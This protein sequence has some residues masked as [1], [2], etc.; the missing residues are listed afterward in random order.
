MQHHSL[1]GIILTSSACE[2]SLSDNVS[3]CPMA[4]A[5][6]TLLS[7]SF[8]AGISGNFCTFWQLS[9]CSA[10]LTCPKPIRVFEEWLL[11]PL[12]F[13]AIP[14]QGVYLGTLLSGASLACHVGLVGEC[15]GWWHISWCG[16]IDE[17]GL[18]QV[19]IPSKF[20]GVLAAERVRVK[21]RGQQ[22][23]PVVY[24]TLFLFVSWKKNVW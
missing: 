21:I 23:V 18:E 3:S 19:Q 8:F 12:V 5:G 16:Q 22:H 24:L 10:S 13:Y 11:Y 14:D 4:S 9:Q 7:A 15:C 2:M 1:S 17:C 6:V 20:D